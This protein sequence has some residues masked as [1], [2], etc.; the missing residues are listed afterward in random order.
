MYLRIHLYDTSVFII[1]AMCPELVGWLSSGEAEVAMCKMQDTSCVYHD[2]LT[3][4]RNIF[5]THFTI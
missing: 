2:S 5:F 4:C 1:A 3:C